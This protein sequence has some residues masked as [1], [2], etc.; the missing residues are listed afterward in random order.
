MSMGILTVACFAAMLG[1]ILATSDLWNAAKKGKTDVVIALINSGADVEASNE[2]GWITIMVATEAGHL[3]TVEALILANANI[4][5]ATNNV[6]SYGKGWTALH[7]AAHKKQSDIAQ[8][9]LRTGADKLVKDKKGKIPADVARKKGYS[10]L[11]K[12]IDDFIRH[13]FTQYH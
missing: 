13:H 3:D 10:Q 12:I 6:G 9:L 7:I 4:S 5:A 2:N 1:A 8:L 11:A